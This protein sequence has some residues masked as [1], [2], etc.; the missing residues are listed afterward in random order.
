MPQAISKD[1]TLWSKDWRRLQ[2]QKHRHRG[3]VEARMLTA[4]GMYFGEMYMAQARD[5]I[6]VRPLDAADRNKLFL[7]FNLL[8][9][10][11]KRKVGRLWA[12]GNQNE[13]YATPDVRDPKA[14]DQADTVK[15]VIKGLNKRL[16]EKLQHWRR[17]WWI[18]N[19]GV[20]IEHTPWIEDKTEEP[21]PVI[22]ED[23]SPMWRDL[24]NPDKQ[25]LLTEAEVM[26]I[27][28]SNPN[29]PPEQ[30][31]IAETM[32][33]VGDVGSQI[34][35]GFNFFI[36]SS[37]PTIEE[38]GPKQACYIL[39]CKTV[40]WI[41]ETFGNDVADQIPSSAGRDL[42]IVK[43]RLLDRGPSVSGLNL[44]DLIPAIQGS[45]GPGDPR[46]ALVATRYEAP[47]HEWPHGRRSVFVPDA[48]VLDDQEPQD[49]VYGEVPLTDLH[50]GAPTTT[51]WT[52]DFLT[53]AIPANKFLNKRMSQLGEANNAQ[54]YEI[55]LLGPELTSDA[56]PSDMPG[57]VEDG[58]GDDGQ[59]RAAVMQ[60]GA[61]PAFAIESIKL[62]MQLFQM[63]TSADLTDHQQYPGQLR[64]PMALP[65]L[66]ELIDSEDGPLYEH[67]GEQLAR[68]HQ[69]RIN[70]V[71]K[72]YP[73]L[74]TMHYT[75]TRR[76][77]EVFVFHTEE[78][79]RSGTEFSISV[80]PAT[81]YP[82]LS[83]LVEAQL[84]ERLSSPLAGMYVNKRT[85][86]MDFTKIAAELKYDDDGVEDRLT[87]Y[88]DLAMHLVARLW[89]GETLPPDVPAPF[90]DHD[91]VLDELEASMATTE[92][93]G[94]S[95]TVKA[96]FTAF[97]ERC[98]QYL[99]AIQDAA[100][101]ATQN[102]MQQGMIAQVSQ[103][104]AAK[105]AADTMG[106][107]EQQIH[108]QIDAARTNPPV[109]QLSQALLANRRQ[110]PQSALATGQP[111]R[112][113]LPPMRGGQPP[114]PT[115]QQPQLRPRG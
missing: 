10:A 100:M 50:F 41:T 103:Q 72:F 105:V 12:A 27:V 54:L 59:P 90:W 51:F 49:S 67:M 57:V 88:R 91:T 39:E 45:Q 21:M 19:T 74:R 16:R 86:K 46:L 14:Y 25:A 87:Q 78:I 37:T 69:Q 11:S 31:S 113:G 65:M 66:Q 79:L 112:R 40:D 36:D 7:V 73:A 48:V 33:L 60:R 8:K 38:M 52:D 30:F 108:A 89:K 56:I 95:D 22:G 81:L 106:R 15:R 35:S 34:I 17:L 109:Q 93:I 75:G 71:K 80:N 76:K 20:V 102:Q 18:V 29:I 9:R 85:G 82:K 62:I 111:V 84:V 23:G 58:L 98:R 2:Q 3:G 6:L 26:A 110:Q 115:P 28:Q 114:Q 64:G 13:F 77:D 61:L 97:Y 42:G 44:K 24:S 53:D 63:I 101:Q 32:Q 96:N 92:Y 4:I 99:A 68:M 107:A 55:I 1:V 5:S 94:A 83:A 47:C 43:T 104:V 70:R